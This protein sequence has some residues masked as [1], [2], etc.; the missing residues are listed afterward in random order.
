MGRY[1]QRSS[2]TSTH[3]QLREIIF[4]VKNFTFSYAFAMVEHKLMIFLSSGLYMCSFQLTLFNFFWQLG[5][6]QQSMTF[7]V[8]ELTSKIH[9][10]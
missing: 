3:I 9:Y 10:R 1:Q 8:V 4:I 7:W 5:S 6:I 2:W